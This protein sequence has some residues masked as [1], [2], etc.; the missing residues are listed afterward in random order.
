MA[1]ITPDGVQEPDAR[2]ALLDATERLMLSEGYAAVTSR[3]VAAEAGVNPGLVYYYFGPMDEL[4]LE[5]FRRSAAR[6]L[7]RQAE[8]LAAEQPLWA[9]W[10]MIRDQT[11]T[12]LNVEFLAL[13]NHRKA[14]MAEMKEFS[15]RFRR[16]QFEGLS[17]ILTKYGVD[18]TQ[19]PAEAVMLLMDAAA[20]FMGEERS[21]GLSL[22]H[23]QTVTVVE[24]LIS[25]LEGKRRARKRRKG[26]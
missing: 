22:G 7:D 9:L 17:T 23:S 11:N 24:R 10:D 14:V 18:T 21:Y 20:R 8:A 12:A 1:S 26:K 5:V 3:R 4:F 2:T 19:W 15:V 16:L 25:Q 13:G 6:S